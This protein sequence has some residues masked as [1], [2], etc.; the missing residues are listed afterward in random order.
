MDTA[1]PSS[2][3]PT[4]RIENT[5]PALDKNATLIYNEAK[6]RVDPE[7]VELLLLI[8]RIGSLEFVK[9]QNGKPC[10]AQREVATNLDC[11]AKAN[12]QL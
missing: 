8:Q 1:T 11:T 5:T 9:I 7:F 6:H 12:T 4:W 2:R 10:F 3:W